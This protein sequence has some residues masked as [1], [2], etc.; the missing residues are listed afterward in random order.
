[1]NKWQ[2]DLTAQFNGIQ[3]L[4]Y[5]GSNTPANQ[6]PNESDSYTLLMG[7]VTKN[8][9][10]WSFYVGAENL[11]N[12]TQDNA[13]ISADDPFGKEFDAS[14]VWAPLYGRMFYFG[15]KFTLDKK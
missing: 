15:I 7:Q 8:Y 6:R 4:P 13:I 11:T 12:Y 1:M 14:M 9:R 2:F 5:T 10:N 3:R